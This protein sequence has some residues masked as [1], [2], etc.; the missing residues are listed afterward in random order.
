ML[1]RIGRLF[2]G[3]GSFAFHHKSIEVFLQQDR[4]RLGMDPDN[5]G[6]DLS[7]VSKMARAWS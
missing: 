6:F 7:I 2:H 5:T 4:N 1:A 3:D